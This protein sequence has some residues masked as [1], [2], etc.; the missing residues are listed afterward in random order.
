M[1][2]TS[3]FTS[4]GM[5][6]ETNRKK[7]KASCELKHCLFCERAMYESVKEEPPKLSNMFF[8]F[9]VGSTNRKVFQI[10]ESK[11]GG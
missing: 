4:F 6:R 8:V 11:F 10:F 7:F 2:L 3:N 5:A 1:T 9:R